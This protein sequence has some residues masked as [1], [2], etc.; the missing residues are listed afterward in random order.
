MCI[1]GHRRHRRRSCLIGYV[2]VCLRTN[3]C[4]RDYVR[5]CW[6]FSCNRRTKRTQIQYLH[7]IF[8]DTLLFIIRRPLGERERTGEGNR[9]TS[10]RTDAAL[11]S[12]EMCQNRP[13][14]WHGVYFSPSRTFILTHIESRTEADI[15]KTKKISVWGVWPRSSI[16]WSNWSWNFIFLTRNYFKWFRKLDLISIRSVSVEITSGL[17]L[18]H[19]STIGKQT[20]LWP[21]RV[22][23]NRQWLAVYR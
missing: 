18:S 15:M 1:Y 21:K 19:H 9:S 4:Q 8:P 12:L 2:A 14:Q 16:I 11:G 13:K 22:E 10:Y 7:S 20:H 23:K 3:V 6:F 17:L 5:V